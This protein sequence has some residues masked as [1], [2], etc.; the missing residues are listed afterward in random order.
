MPNCPVW[1]ENK[2]EFLY[3]PSA[4]RLGKASDED[5]DYN[6]K[7]KEKE[8]KK[9]KKK[10]ADPLRRKK[11]SHS[12]AFAHD[13]LQLGQFSSDSEDELVDSPSPA[14]P[15]R[16][17]TAPPLTGERRH[18][19]T[20]AQKGPFDGVNLPRGFVRT[21]SANPLPLVVPTTQQLRSLRDE[22]GPFTVG[23]CLHCLQLDLPCAASTNPGGACSRCLSDHNSG[24]CSHQMFFADVERS[25]SK[26]YQI[27][28][29]NIH[30]LCRKAIE[31]FSV[32]ARVS[33]TRVLAYQGEEE[34][35]SRALCTIFS[36]QQYDDIIEPV[37]ELYQLDDVVDAMETA[38]SH[39]DLARSGIPKTSKTEGGVV[40]FRYSEPEFVICSVVLA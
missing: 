6:R 28:E 5:S 37:L 23:D 1:Y 32:E 39:F 26:T 34:L 14:N 33:A 11:Q 10:K 27:V 24:L 31:L 20:N 22:L 25:F 7:Q 17:G 15:W 36:Q 29:A 16:G 12:M 13:L 30:K 38:Y 3:A 2:A 4:V 40:A 8:K 21:R 18:F 19:F 9:K 35:D